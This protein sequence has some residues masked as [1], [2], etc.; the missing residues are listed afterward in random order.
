MGDKIGI[1]IRNWHTCSC[2]QTSRSIVTGF[3]ATGSKVL[4][5][6]NRLRCPLARWSGLQCFSIDMGHNGHGINVYG[7]II[8]LMGKIHVGGHSDR[9]T[10]SP[11]TPV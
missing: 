8:T 2:S 7:V 9:G 4:S 1:S 10:L 11:G 5:R 3:Q 6:G